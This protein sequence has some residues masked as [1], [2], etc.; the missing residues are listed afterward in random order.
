MMRFDVVST[1]KVWLEHKDIDLIAFT[2]SR[3]VGLAINEAA[4]RLRAGR[5]QGG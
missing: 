1:R 3:P 5:E 4:A 2:G